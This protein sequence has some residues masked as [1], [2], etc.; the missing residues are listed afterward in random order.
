LEERH[1]H[2]VEA[3]GSRPR[4]PTEQALLGPD[5]RRTA[6]IVVLDATEVLSLRRADF[7][8]PRAADGRG[9]FPPLVARRPRFDTAASPLNRDRAD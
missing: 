4:S 6:S 1:V 7:A 3:R 5:A 8:A 2:T 9:R